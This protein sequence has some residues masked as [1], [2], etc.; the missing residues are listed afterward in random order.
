MSVTDVALKLGV[1]KALIYRAI[2]RKEFPAL[3]LGRKILI[4]LEAFD[5]FVKSATVARREA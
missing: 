2:S 5:Q 4:P 1:E 3:R